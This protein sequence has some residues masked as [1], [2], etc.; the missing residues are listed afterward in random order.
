[1][2]EAGVSE[3]VMGDSWHRLTRRAFLRNAGLAASLT[4]LAQLRVAPAIAVAAADEP[5]TALL[6]TDDIETLTQIVERMVA[7]DDPRS[8][9]VRKTG[10]IATIDRLLGQLDPAL[11]SDVPLVLKLFDWGPVV[12]DFTFSRFTRM[13]AEAQDESIRCWMVSRLGLRR[14]AYAALRNLAFIGYYSQDA[15]WQAIGYQ[16]PL[17]VGRVGG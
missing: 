15:V 16:G 3:T 6:S 10:A 7:S 12:F 1:V 13:S 17:L 9:P 14:Q 5:G 8:P 4:A 2:S 11:T